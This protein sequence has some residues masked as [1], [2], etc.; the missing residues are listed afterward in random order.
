ME[1]IPS[2]ILYS[3]QRSEMN[4]INRMNRTNR[5]D[6]NDRYNSAIS[7]MNSHFDE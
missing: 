5:D 1:L 6:L 4:R 2:A 7:N 3:S